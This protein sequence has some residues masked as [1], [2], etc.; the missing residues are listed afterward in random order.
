MMHTYH[1]IQ[2]KRFLEHIPIDQVFVKKTYEKLQ[3]KH[4]CTCNF[5]C[6]V[7][8]SHLCVYGRLDSTFTKFDTNH[9][10]TRDCLGRLIFYVGETH[11]IYIYNFRLFD[12]KDN[13]EDPNLVQ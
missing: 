3:L 13:I 7:R 11:T 5:T 6:I 2:S 1:E 9:L 10:V 8:P 4:T 12:S